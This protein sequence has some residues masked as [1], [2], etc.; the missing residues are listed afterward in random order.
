MADDVQQTTTPYRPACG[1]EGIDFMERWC[2]RCWRDAAFQA[3]EGD[4][5]IIAANTMAF[6]V[7]DPDYPAEWVT[8]ATGPR[9]TAFEPV[10]TG[11]A[12]HDGQQEA[13]AI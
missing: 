5:C 9:C 12:I 6:A 3:G 11:G 10:E 8:D 4:S 2:A 13:L 1:S 7:S